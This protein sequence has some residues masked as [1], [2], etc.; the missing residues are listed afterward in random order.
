MDPAVLARRRRLTTRGARL[1]CVR[2]TA[3][4]ADAVRLRPALGKATGAANGVSG[5]AC[6]RSGPSPQ[7]G[8]ARPGTGGLPRPGLASHSEPPRSARRD[9]PDH[10]R[11]PLTSFGWRLFSVCRGP[12]R[13]RAR[14][15]RE[16]SGPARVDSRPPREASSRSPTSDKPA[17][18]PV[19]EGHRE[20]E[21]VRKRS[22]CG[23]G[24][25]AEAEPVRKRGQCGSGASS[26]PPRA[27]ASP[28]AGAD[29][30][31]P[32]NPTKRAVVARTKM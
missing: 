15:S 25:S 26:E 12:N 30:T 13:Q 10:R 9:N 14:C 28:P 18:V 32:T 20:A 8:A 2:P 19:G 21:P 17:A 29:R 4:A 1:R 31:N 5:E 3:T 11:R 16:D 7:G 23:S 24:T 27:R 6:P 22:Q